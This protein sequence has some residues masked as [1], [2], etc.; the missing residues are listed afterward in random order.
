MGK[1]STVPSNSSQ[2]G[3]QIWITNEKVEWNVALDENTDDDRLT[4]SCEEW[5]CVTA[6]I[7]GLMSQIM[8]SRCCLYL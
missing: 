7:S 5:E 3:D 2:N 1:M 8:A 6:T 4:L